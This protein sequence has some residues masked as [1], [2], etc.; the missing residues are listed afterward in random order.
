VNLLEYNNFYLVGIK[1]VA[2]TS[3]AQI[4][5]DAN[6]KVSGSDIEEEF[7]TQEILNKIQVKIDHNFETPLP[8]EIDCVIYTAAHDALENPQVK[9]ALNR[10][11]PV[12]SQAEAMAWF[13]NQQ[14]GVAV[15]GVGGKSTVSAMLTWILNDLELKPSFSVGVGSI[16]GLEKTGQWNPQAKY[17]IAEADEY[18]INP[19]AGESDEEIIPRFSFLKP[20][21]TICTNLK[22]DHP[23]VY[24]DFKHS[25][26][27]YNQFFSQIKP[28]GKLIINLNDLNYLNNTSLPTL[29]FGEAPAA[30]LYLKNYHSKEGN[31]ISEFYYQQQKFE[32][33]LQI[34][35]KFNVLNALA[36]ILAATQLEIEPQQA[37]LALSTFSSTK[38]RF[39]YIGEKN[40]VK[41]YDDYAH[42]PHEIKATV[43]ALDDWYPQQ[44]KVIAF[45]SHTYSRTKELFDE[46]VESFSEA[47]E[48]VMIDIF[49]SAREKPD[50]TISSTKLC[51]AIENKYHSS[52]QNLKSIEKLAQYCKTQLNSGDILITLGA[53]DIY[54]VHEII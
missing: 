5:I 8:S 39:E 25:K 7:V 17:F 53:G 12:I 31:T 45:Q 27:T 41:Y 35:G 52:A 21:L 2:M 29:T 9:E 38:R 13:F 26:Q 15:C 36:A 4:L 30:D 54:L 10:Q 24:Q 49:S 19:Q 32:L 48:V 34:P 18:V 47:K 42:H 43:D 51:E 37:I 14:Q 1:G 16:P 20:Q 33:K 50:P 44:R 40:G 23:D 6:K 3:M 22:F 28:N 11:I 46:F